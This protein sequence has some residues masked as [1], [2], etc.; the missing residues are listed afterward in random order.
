MDNKKYRGELL[1]NHKK[2]LKEAE[3][4]VLIT[5]TSPHTSSSGLHTK[6][7]DWRG[8]LRISKM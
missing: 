8:K 6:K 1:N 2:V 5:L 3:K 7:Y 4:Q